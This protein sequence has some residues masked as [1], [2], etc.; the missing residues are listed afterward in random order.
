MLA[1]E[2]TCLSDLFEAPGSDR[3][4]DSVLRKIRV[5]K[6]VRQERDGAA[7]ARKEGRSYQPSPRIEKLARS[8][9]RPFAGCDGEGGGVNDKGQQ[10]YRLLRCGEHVLFHDNRPL[11]TAECLDFICDLPA[12]PIHVGFAFGY[13]TTQILRDLPAKVVQSMFERQEQAWGDDVPFNE[14][15]SEYVHWRN[16]G[17]AYRSGQYLA[18][19]RLDP[20]SNRGIKGSTRIIYETFGFFQ[21]S[22][23]ATLRDYRIGDPAQL[24]LM[25]A[26]KAERGDFE[27]MTPEH[28]AYNAQECKWLAQLMEELRRRCKACG[29][30][31]HTWSGAGK[32]AAALMKQYRVIKQARVVELTEPEAYWHAE[33]AYYGGRSEIRGPGI[34]DPLIGHDLRSAYMA[35]MVELPCLEHARWERLTARPGPGAIWIA[36]VR[37]RHPKGNVWC[38]LPWRH[39]HGGLTYPRIGRGTYWGCEIEAAERIGAKITF[40]KGWQ[41]VPG[42]Q[43]KP[44]GFLRE[45]YDRRREMEERM[46]GS[47]IPL[48]LAGNSVYG[49][50]VQRIGQAPYYNPIWGGLITAQIRAWMLD[51]L[52]SATDPAAVVYIATDGIFATERLKLPAA[53]EGTG[54]GQWEITDY[55]PSC[56]VMP[57]MYWPLETGKLGDIKSRGVPRTRVEENTLALEAAWRDYGRRVE[58]AVASQRYEGSS[59]P[60]RA[61]TPF[62]AVRIEVGGFTGLRLAAAQGK[63]DRA[64]HWAKKPEGHEVTCKCEA[65]EEACRTISF[66]WYLKREVAWLHGVEFAGEDISLITQPLEGLNEESYHWDR[67]TRAKAKDSKER[68]LDTF[69]RHGQPDNVDPFDLAVMGGDE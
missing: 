60:F 40:R 23:V 55:G 63:I 11:T 7:R 38:G 69:W 2:E 27:L 12:K 53:S 4:Y 33:H 17:I 1:Q 43:E 32:L 3:Y 46:P 67:E 65:C 18:V 68:D 28:L 6:S 52:A 36:D 26:M 48:K 19:R 45:V 13:D 51:A 25:E 54:I 29:I 14:R 56:M 47:G 39:N 37:F 22:F 16:F 59:P 15:P 41:L 58:R 64:G 49:K 24:D 61:P 42:C 31:P 20:Y 30:V 5:K 34:I 8:G 35:A 50:L 66:K 62:P 57:G 9:P 21:K 44:L 10:H